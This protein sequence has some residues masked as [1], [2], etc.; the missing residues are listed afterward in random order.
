MSTLTN[1]IS[2]DFRSA[3]RAVDE[4]K[5]DRNQWADCVTM[6]HSTIHGQNWTTRPRSDGN[7]RIGEHIWSD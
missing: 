7:C 4:S 5:S 1:R 6:S 3:L 2:G